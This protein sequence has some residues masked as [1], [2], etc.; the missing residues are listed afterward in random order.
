M[1][2]LL[3]DLQNVQQEKQ[4]KQEQVHVVFDNADLMRHI[5]SKCSLSPKTTMKRNQ[6]DVGCRA[7][8][9]MASMVCRQ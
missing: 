3:A 8:L 2:M 1:F 7:T 9:L 5:F 6:T 4:E